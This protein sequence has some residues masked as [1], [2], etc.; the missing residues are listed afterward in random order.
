MTLAHLTSMRS[1]LAPGH[2]GFSRQ[3]G[4]SPYCRNKTPWSRPLSLLL[5]VSGRELEKGSKV[6]GFGVLLGVLQRKRGC[7]KNQQ[8]WQEKRGEKKEGRQQSPSLSVC[9]LASPPTPITI[10][11][12]FLPSSTDFLRPYCM[13]SADPGTK[14]ESVS[15]TDTIFADQQETQRFKQAGT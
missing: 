4:A 2:S 10:M 6:K 5:P 14:D 13:L 7:W 9:L 8:S 11:T 12:S 1:L 15:S 3:F